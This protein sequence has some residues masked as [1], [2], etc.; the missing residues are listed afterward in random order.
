[1][2]M[3]S[4]LVPTV[5]YTVTM[6]PPTETVNVILIGSLE[7]VM[8]VLVEDV[9]GICDAPYAHPIC[10]EC[11]RQMYVVKAHTSCCKVF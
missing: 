11:T 4:P 6:P 1:M 3:V 2:G 7:M 9:S 5:G 10:C 8:L